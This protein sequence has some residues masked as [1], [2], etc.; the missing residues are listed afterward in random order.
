MLFAKL[1]SMPRKLFWLAPTVLNNLT[2]ISSP[3]ISCV[4]AGVRKK[5]WIG[6]EF[7]LKKYQTM[8]GY[9]SPSAARICPSVTQPELVQ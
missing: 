7:F 2:G 3:C 1:D 5:M 9:L 6:E 8:G 4:G